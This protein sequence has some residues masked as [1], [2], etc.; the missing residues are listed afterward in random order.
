MAYSRVTLTKL[1]EINDA[2]LLVNAPSDPFVMSV[3]QQRVY[4]AFVEQEIDRLLLGVPNAGNWQARY[5]LQ[6]YQ[7]A[8]EQV[9]GELMR[10]GAQI[11]PTEVE[12]LT[13]QGLTPFSATPT[14][15]TGPTTAPVHREALEFLYTRSYESLQGW[16]SALSRETRQILFDGVELG[17]QSRVIARKLQ[18]RINV[19]EVRARRIAQ[20]ETNQ[21]YSRSSIAEIDRAAEETG[22][23]IRTR[24]ITARDSRV[25]HTHA[26]LH[27]QVMTTD[28]ARRIKTEDGINCRCALIPVVPGTNTMKRQ[29]RY[30]AE[31]QQLL[32]LRAA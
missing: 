29:A 8:L 10:Q 4:M 28:E 18:E 17:E 15:G 7:Q 32:L 19:S 31:R 23:D 26:E 1:Y 21:A 16:T 12:R 14:L 9:R 22:E 3:G 24:W 6:S 30:D 2:A 25:R 20:T 13:A 27:G 5:E 11:V